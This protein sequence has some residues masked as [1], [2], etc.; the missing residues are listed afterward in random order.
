M[1][2]W[3]EEEKHLFSLSLSLSLQ[4][5]V[6]WK[7]GRA[8]SRRGWCGAPTFTRDGTKGRNSAL[9]VFVWIARK[10]GI[11]WR[12]GGKKRRNAVLW[13]NREREREMPNEKML[14]NRKKKRR[15]KVT[16][17][18]SLLRAHS[19]NLIKVPLLIPSASISFRFSLSISTS[20]IALLLLF[21]PT[22]QQMSWFPLFFFPKYQ[23]AV[24]REANDSSA[25]KSLMPSTPYQKSFTYQRRL[26]RKRA[27][28]KSNVARPV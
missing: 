25:R 8:D 13:R 9:A 18:P 17:P 12:G 14:L 28:M 5:C 27:T 22:A 23:K 2:G 11:E 15:R 24:S 6:W 1:D 20:S 16:S 3:M 10:I 4:F 19:G 21:C 26:K 7:K